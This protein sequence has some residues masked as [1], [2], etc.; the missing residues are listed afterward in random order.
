ME[1]V[2][3]A[4]APL[5]LGAVPVL[6]APGMPIAAVRRRLERAAPE[7]FIG[8]PLAQAARLALGWARHSSRVTITLGS[9]RL[10]PEPTLAGLRAAARSRA[11]R[12]PAGRPVTGP[13]SAGDLALIACTSGS[14]G[15][16]CG[17]GDAI[18]V[19]RCPHA[20]V[21]R[22]ATRRTASTTKRPCPGSPET[23]SE[24]GGATRT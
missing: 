17:A 14:T 8:I 16:G 15:P 3:L 6:L 24:L 2:A 9:R 7:A 13:P 22:P 10:W 12:H 20:G 21:A 23:A 4:R 5:R 18:G 1:L 19:K 11:P